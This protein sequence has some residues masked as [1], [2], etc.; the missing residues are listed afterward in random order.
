MA[1]TNI[2]IE[3]DSDLYSKLK[4][5]QINHRMESKKMISL[6]N[7]I[8]HYFDEGY[9]N[10]SIE[11]PS[12]LRTIID[13]NNSESDQSLSGDNNNQMLISSKFE[14]IISQIEENNYVIN[15]AL[16]KLLSNSQQSINNSINS[17]ISIADINNKLTLLSNHLFKLGK[18]TISQND[19]DDI[20]IIK[21][22][23]NN[24]DRN[25]Q[26]SQIEKIIP[27]VTPLLLILGYAM[28]QKKLNKN[29]DKEAIKPF[30]NIKEIIS[31]LPIDNKREIHQFIEQ[32]LSNFE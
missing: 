3:V 9:T 12:G 17:T 4:I 24:I 11:D 31:E 1:I 21:K 25:T 27:Y 30:E 13:Y 8:M 7:V 6:A 18:L 20:S 14:E 19:N 28:I 26:K 2:R 15:E 29:Q 16:S 23:I 5:E 10:A 22:S 32:Y